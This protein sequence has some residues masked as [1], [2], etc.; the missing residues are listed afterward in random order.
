MLM[1]A[2]ASA[3][4]TED[5]VEIFLLSAKTVLLM[6]RGLNDYFAPGYLYAEVHRFPS[7]GPEKNWKIEDATLEPVLGRQVNAEWAMITG[8]KAERYGLL[9][10]FTGAGDY[11]NNV[12]SRKSEFDRLMALKP[13]NP[14]VTKLVSVV[15]TIAVPLL[16]VPLLSLIVVLIIV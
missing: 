5:G 8:S 6:K 3:V 15:S 13:P 2:A 11:L 9:D 10:V 1:E 12:D 7:E 14:T 4:G 16:L